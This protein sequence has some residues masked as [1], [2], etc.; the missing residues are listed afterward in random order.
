MRFGTFVLQTSLDP[1]LDS[2]IID[3]TLKEAELAEALGFDAI[4]LTE[5][6]FGGGTVYADP[7]VFGAAVAVRTK[8]IKVGFAVVQMAFHHPVKLAAQTALLDN[9]SHGRLIVGTGRGSGFNAFEYIGFGTTLEE[10]RSRLVEAEDLLV[11]AWTTKDLDY[12]GNY[13]TVAFPMLR[14]RPYQQ[15]HP[16]LVRACQSEE[17]L[18]DMA[19]IGRPVLIPALHP[20]EV[21]RRLTLYRDTMLTAGFDEH[22]VEKALDET[23]NQLWVYVDNDNQRAQEE[24]LA[25]FQ[26]E[27]DDISQAAEQYNPVNASSTISP[28]PKTYMRLDNSVVAGSPNLVTERLSALKDVGARNILLAMTPTHLPRHKVIN[29]MR[30]FADV[31][32]PRFRK[33]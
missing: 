5:H 10:G 6:Y 31:V 8:T 9:L 32:A 3:N 30:L 23:W 11:K 20:E 4:W 27:R 12:K 29:S 14:P 16:P 21:D 28:L 33:A 15:P 18:V 2:Q 17:S 25:A 1:K 26:A 19:K 24:G 13:W 22:Y 7:L